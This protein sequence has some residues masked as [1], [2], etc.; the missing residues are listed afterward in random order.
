L[1]ANAPAGVRQLEAERRP[2]SR[3]RYGE[4]RMPS[5]IRF[6]ERLEPR[7]EFSVPLRKQM[8]DALADVS[9]REVW[10]SLAKIDNQVKSISLPVFLIGNRALFR[11]DHFDLWQTKLATVENVQ[12]PFCT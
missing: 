3:S 10:R 1:I 7:S 2:Q 12:Q 11:K 5:S 4:A 9:W 6:E 8:M